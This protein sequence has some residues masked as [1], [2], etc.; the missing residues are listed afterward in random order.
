MKKCGQPAVTMKSALTNHL[1]GSFALDQDNKQPRLQTIRGYYDTFDTIHRKFKD[2]VLTILRAT[3]LNREDQEDIFNA[4]MLRISALLGSG[5]FHRIPNTTSLLVLR[6]T[7]GKV[8]IS[9]P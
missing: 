5:R 4:V 2:K 3:R 7:D 8:K 6:I 1:I 9:L